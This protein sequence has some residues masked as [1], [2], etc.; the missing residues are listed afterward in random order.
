MSSVRQLVARLAAAFGWRR[1]AADLHP[2]IHAHPDALADDHV[3]RGMSSHDAK[4]AARRD[5]GGVA[6][7]SER[8]R[9]QRGLPVLDALVM[10]LRYALRIARKNPGFA[11]VAILTLG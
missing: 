7:M 11:A 5:F 3:R 8:Y 1:A 6:Q 2:E 10:D 4:L 9:D